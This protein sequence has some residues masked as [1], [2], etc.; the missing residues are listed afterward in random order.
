MN[1]AKLPATLSAAIFHGS[2]VAFY[3]ASELLG[4]GLKQFVSRSLYFYRAPPV[5]PP[6]P[7]KVA[8]LSRHVVP[9]LCILTH[10]LDVPRL[11]RTRTS[12]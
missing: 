1:E 2:V 9:N 3:S 8:S 4:V 11:G 7:V 5:C 12:D 6:P 10:L